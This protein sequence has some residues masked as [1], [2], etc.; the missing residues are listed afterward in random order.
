[1]KYSRFEDLPVWQAAA[2]LAAKML[3]WTQLLSFRGKGD[4]ASQLQRAALSISNNI[5]EGFERGTTK[6]LLSFLYI[7]RD[8]AGEVRSMLCVMERMPDFSELRSEVSDFKEACES[9]SRQ[10]RGWAGSLQNSDIE[11]QRHLNDQSRAQY[12]VQNR[13]ATFVENQRRWRTD[14]EVQ[15]NARAAARRDPERVTESPSTKATTP[16]TKTD[17]T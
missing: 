17:E 16:E 8:S 13:Q 4:L 11:G 3:G 1:M 2:E 9:I 14:F 6:E 12:D 10:I 5:A 15:L 7:A